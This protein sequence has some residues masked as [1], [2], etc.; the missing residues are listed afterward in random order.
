[1]LYRN[2]KKILSKAFDSALDVAKTAKNGYELNIS[3]ASS[4]MEKHMVDSAQKMINEGKLSKDAI[5]NNILK[6]SAKDAFRVKYN[7]SSIVKHGQDPLMNDMANIGKVAAAAVVGLKV[8]Q[9]AV[10]LVSGDW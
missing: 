3:K 6:L 4:E 1:M 9:G 7:K 2:V 5:S 8:T 10:N